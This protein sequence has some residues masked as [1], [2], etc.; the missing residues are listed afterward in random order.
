MSDPE[1]VNRILAALKQRAAGGIRRCDL[2]RALGVRAQADVRAFRDTFRDLLADGRIVKKRG[3]RYIPAAR[4]GLTPGT[5]SVHPR[6]FGFVAPDQGRPD[7]FIP[8]RGIG[9]A[10]AGDRVLVRITET[11]GERGPAGVIHKVLERARQTVTGQLVER[12]GQ[13]YLR[14]LRRALPET[15]PVIAAPSDHDGSVAAATG[16][17]V[18]G[19]I[20]PTEDG[21]DQLRAMLQRRLGSGETIAGDLDA[22]AAEYG[23]E[24]PYSAAE[25][26]AAATLAP[27]AAEREDIT[28]ET[29]ITIDPEDAKDFD[30]ALSVRVTKQEGVL[31][32][33]VHIA[34][35]ASFVIPDSPLDQCARRR[36]FTAY[37]PGRTLPMLPQ[38]LAAD[39][40]SL[41]AGETR[42]AHSLFLR[43]AAATGEILASR[44]C[45][46]L[47]RVTQRLNFEVVRQFLDGDARDVQTA[48]ATCLE[49]LQ[50]LAQLLRTRR[51]KHESFLDLALPQVRVRC[52]E[53]PPQLLGLVREE[54]GPAHMLVEEFMLA[55]NTAVAM[56][57]ERRRIPALFRVHPEPDPDDMRSLER[58][59]ALLPGH[60][61]PD[62]RDRNAVNRL[63]TDLAASPLRDVALGALLS[64]LPRAMY[65][66]RPAPHFGLGKPTYCHFTSPIRRYADLVVHQQLLAADRGL[67][68]RSIQDCTELGRHCSECEANQDE[69]YYAATARLK[70]RYLAR[71]EEHKAEIHEGRIAR[72]S[73]D[74][75]GVYLAELGMIGN[76][77]RAALGPGQVRFRREAGTLRH[78]QSGK[79]YKCGDVITVQILRIDRIRGELLLEPARIRLPSSERIGTRKDSSC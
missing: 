71:R 4:A 68:L 44:R 31:E 55:A 73:S 43:I 7:I 54:G 12:N 40:C 46:T 15:I 27:A 57:L 29:T 61:L 14:P 51:L 75:L 63:V 6:G 17:W 39:R 69:A 22:V 3:G 24:P 20:C 77:N 19:S 23:L 5:L 72:V 49:L 10:L 28:G 53:D 11:D 16:D 42:P 26:A 35:V 59:D 41:V 21:R 9:A 67:A 58:L 79:T 74:G 8:P 32:V 2:R 33:G 64:C 1:L 48:A 30:D 34:D 25:N 65:E 70:L 18:E 38:P 50:P 52:T 37:L 45:L 56:E 66:A 36:A 76:V 60:R 13:L 47:I 78:A 62:L